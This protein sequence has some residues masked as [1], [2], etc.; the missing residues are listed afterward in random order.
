[1]TERLGFLQ[2]LFLCG[3]LLTTVYLLST[4]V[5]AEGGAEAVYK[6]KCATCHGPDGVG[7]TPAG[8]AT[9]SRDFCSDEVKKETDEE[10]TTIIVK[11][12]NKMPA[13]DKKITEAEIKDV[14]AYIR[15]FCKK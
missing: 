7:A 9:K 5:N 15:G 8:K 13:Y 2:V 1:M 12:K 11:G 6:A 10:W 14:V 3:T 4:P